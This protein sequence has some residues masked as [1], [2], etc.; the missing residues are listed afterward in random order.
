MRRLQNLF[1]LV[2]V[3]FYSLYL[4]VCVCSALCS[5]RQSCPAQCTIHT[6]THI[7]THTNTHI[8]KDWKHM[9]PLDRT[10]SVNDVF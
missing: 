1:G 8:N 2:A 4:C 5:V 6:H 10:N 9:Q 7:H 3:Y